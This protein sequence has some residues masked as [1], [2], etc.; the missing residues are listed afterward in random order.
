MAVYKKRSTTRVPASLSSSYL[1]GSP[2][3]GT[4]TMTLTSCG[5]LRPTAI[6]SMRICFLDD[7]AFKARGWGVDKAPGGGV[8][9]GQ[10]GPH[11]GGFAR[12]G[13]AGGG[14]PYSACNRR[15]RRL[16]TPPPAAP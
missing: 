2:P 3:V 4:S 12:P 8:Q 5:T 14:A 9:R 7:L 11:P 13:L 1:I 6:L 16:S 10:M 15:G